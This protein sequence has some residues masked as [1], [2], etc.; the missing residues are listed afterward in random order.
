MSFLHLSLLAGLAAVAVPIMLHLFGQRQPQLIDFPALRFVR[1]TSQEQ[2]TSWQLR[3]ILLLLLRILLLAALAFAVAR[4]RVHSATLGSVLGISVLGVCAVLASLVAA[5]AF[6]NKRPSS[7]LLTAVVIAL[8]L[9]TSAGL[10]AYRSITSGPSV[11][12]SDQTAPI[13]AALIVDNGPSMLYRSGNEV[14]LDVA[15]ETAKWILE[16]LPI[17]SRVG[18]LSGVPVGALALDPSS[19]ESQVQLIEPRGAHID[20]LA[21]IQTALDLVAKNELER[22]EIYVITDMMATSWSSAQVGLQKL[23][24][25]YKDEVLLQVIDV[26]TQENANWQ[27]GD[28]E[29]D[30][31]SVPAGGSVNIEIDVSKTNSAT[32][33]ATVTVELL[34]EEV[35][36]SLPI[37]RNGELQVPAQRVVDRQV[38]DLGNSA[39][40]RVSLTARDLA[41]GTTHFTIRMD[42]KDPLEIDNQRYVSVVARQQRP[43]LIMA[44][45]PQMGIILQRIVEPNATNSKLTARIGYAQLEQVELE[46]YAVVCLFDPPPL[47]NRDAQRLKTHVES[48]GGLFVILGQGLGSLGEVQGNA[49]EQLLPGT[50]GRIATRPQDERSAFLQVVAP[51]HPVFQEIV[52]VDVPWQFYPIFRSWTFST[53][54]NNAQT[55]ATLSENNEPLLLAQQLGRGQ[56]ITLCTPLPHIDSARQPLWN[57][58]WIAEPRWPAFALLFGSLRTLSGADQE[59][60]NFSVGAPI[61]LINDPTMFPSRYELFMP[62]V[63]SRRV[64]ADEGQLSLGDFETVGTY[65]LRALNGDPNSRGFSINAPAEDTRLDRLPA[66]QL[67]ELLGAGN[68]RVAKDRD[69]LESSVGQARFGRELYPLLMV[70]VAGLFLAEQA[71]SNRFYQVKFRRSKGA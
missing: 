59:S 35:D 45:D 31:D 71:M 69:E 62:N 14:R 66:E 17:D 44:D 21:R 41:E 38:V 43:T 61:S 49:I 28:P 33:A 56:I 4:P 42:R 19:A 22:K 50:L 48:G 9:W 12:S 27:L 47:S 70:L 58:L 54:N 6:A 29:T 1:E 5:V 68:F 20:L 57:E 36:P 51:S 53:L 24:D 30:N 25:E 60:M 34:Q 26:G 65:R 63:Q 52:D 3:H 39:S 2:S 16:Q 23:L 11:P 32:G 55:L 7:I 15:K 64:S 46:D 10:W 13:A 18:I 67:D 40:E 37:I 8:A